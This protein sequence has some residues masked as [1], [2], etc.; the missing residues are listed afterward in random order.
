MRICQPPSTATTPMS[1][2][3]ASAQLRGQPDTPLLT[4]AEVCRSCESLL[5]LD[6]ER[7]RVAEVAYASI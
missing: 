1:F 3:V 4:L 2:T 6:P 5:E 7:D